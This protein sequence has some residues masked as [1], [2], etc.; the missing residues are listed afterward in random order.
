[1]LKVEKLAPPAPASVE[2]SDGPI[3]S[4]RIEGLEQDRMLWW[5]AVHSNR[6]LCEIGFLAWSGI[7]ADLTLVSVDRQR[8]RIVEELDLLR[9]GIQSL[10]AFDKSPWPPETYHA[11]TPTEYRQLFIDEPVLLDL[12]IGPSGLSLSFDG[13]CAITEVLSIDRLRLGLD[14]TRNLRR[15]DVVELTAEELRAVRETTKDKGGIPPE[16]VP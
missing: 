2:I 4:V 10:P 5:R 12:T 3:L 11:T 16:E 7:L 15:V 6:S 14:E 1:L 13:P 9:P 8:I